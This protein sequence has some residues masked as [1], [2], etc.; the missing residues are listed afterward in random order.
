MH[1]CMYVCVCVMVFFS[2]C[3]PGG[4]GGQESSGKSDVTGEEAHPAVTRSS[5]HHAGAQAWAL[6]KLGG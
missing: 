2:V 5:T 4:G 3:L 6:W 1:A